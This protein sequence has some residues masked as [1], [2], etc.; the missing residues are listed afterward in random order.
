MK[1]IDKNYDYYDYLQNP[2]D[3]LVFDRRNSF[4]L[5]KK[6]IADNLESVQYPK[7]KYRFI[8][9]QCGI[10]YWLFLLTI[11]EY[12]RSNPYCNP[13]VKDYS[14]ETLITW[15]NHNK[16]H[17]T[18][19]IEIISFR[20][21]YIFYDHDL[22][23]GTKDFSVDRIRS[24]AEDLKNNVD[25]NDYKTDHVLSKYQIYTSIKDGWKHEIRDI[26]LLKSS[27]IAELIDPVTLFNAIEEHFSISKTESERTEA[28]GTTNNDKITMHGFD[29]KT[30][31][32]GKNK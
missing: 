21:S 23:I 5:T 12:D 24:R 11:T 3:N 20:H 22:Y 32:R 1:I 14:L 13:T 27:G 9:M 15:T 10:T 19:N 30:S 26:P 17:T 29:T 6:I 4:E 7:S 2:D 16:P 28:V 8:L 25:T 31:F 18:I